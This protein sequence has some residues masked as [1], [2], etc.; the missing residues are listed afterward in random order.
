MGLLTNVSTLPSAA[1]S[2][3]ASLWTKHEYQQN[4]HPICKQCNLASKIKPI[5][6][7]DA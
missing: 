4:D 1:E 6:L 5:M 2:A 3:T 7:L